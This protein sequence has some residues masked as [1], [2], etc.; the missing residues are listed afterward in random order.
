MNDFQLSVKDMTFEI[1][2]PFGNEDAAQILYDV[3]RA[4]EEINIPSGQD[5]TPHQPQ[6]NSQS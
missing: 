6:D 5:V 2:T 3:L 4:E 1:L